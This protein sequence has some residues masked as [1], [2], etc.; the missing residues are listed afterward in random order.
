M[1]SRV[2]QALPLTRVFPGWESVEAAGAV[3]PPRVCQ[4]PAR[5]GRPSAAV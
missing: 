5:L 1:K 2:L 4:G 3:G